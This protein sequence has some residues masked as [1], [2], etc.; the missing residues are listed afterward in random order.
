[1]KILVVDD[2]LSMLEMLESFVESLNHVALPAKDGLE[3]FEIWEREKPRIVIADWVMPHVDGLELCRRIREAE[4]KRY[5]YIIIVSGQDTRKDIVKG[6]EAGVDDYLTKPPHFREFKARIKIGERIVSLESELTRRYEQIKDNYFQ[7]I[8]MFS[9]LIEVYNEE[10]GG[11]SRRT[12]EVG[13]WLAKRHP[14]VPEGEYR[15]IEAAGLLHDIGMVGLPD[16]VIRKR[17]VE[18]SGDEKELYRSHPIQ[19]EI[20][21]REIEFLGP[22]ARIA[23]N[24]HE[25]YDGKGF[26]NGLGGDEIPINSRIVCAAS[27]YD[28]MIHKWK[29][30]YEDAP[31]LLMRERGYGL[32]PEIVTYLIE[33][34]HERIREDEARDYREIP[35][36]E[37]EAGMLL[38]RDIRMKQGVLVAPVHTELTGRDIR[39]LKN[40]NEMACISNKVFVFKDSARK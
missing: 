8:R 24:H 22:I 3:A 9:N 33:F 36:D 13:L 1:M 21:L 25:K 38:A 4:F 37:L 12:A 40:Y 2:D 26:P 30:S 27:L 15:D 35:L 18:M 6:L 19:G 5:T 39:K 14:D 32:D 28:D 7:T 10:L 23:R 31:D 17:L 11:H 34:N 20:I 29:V 16:A